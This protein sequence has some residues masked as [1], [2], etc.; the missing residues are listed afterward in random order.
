MRRSDPA[1]LLA[2]VLFAALSVLYL[3][4]DL[5]GDELPISLTWLVPGTL[6]GLG[7]LGIVRAV[8][9]RRDI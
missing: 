8:F 9:G 6:I 1:S 5:S 2:G 7:M 4:S 3:A